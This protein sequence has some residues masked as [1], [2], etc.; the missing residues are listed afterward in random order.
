[1]AVTY[2]IPAKVA[3]MAATRDYF[4]G[5]T[6]EIISGTGTI[7]VCAYLSADGGYVD[8]ETWHLGFADKEAI[9]EGSGVPADARLKAAN[10]DIGLTGLTIGKG[11]DIEIAYAAKA[12][13]RIHAGQVVGLSGA[14]ITH[15]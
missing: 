5:G 15:A 13:Q 11:K 1:M 14:A 12:E 10:G 4:A 8:G 7:L 9:A 2:S 6:L 3:R